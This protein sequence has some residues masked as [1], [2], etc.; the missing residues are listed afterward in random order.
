M[1]EGQDATLLQRRA[2]RRLVGSVAL[3]LLVVLVLPI[4]LD[5]EPSPVSQDLVIQIPSKDAGKFN[6]RVLPPSAP[7]A[8]DAGKVEAEK[9]AKTDA[10]KPASDT[11]PAPATKVQASK[12]ERTAKA[13]PDAARALALLE[14]KEAGGWVIPLGAFSNSENVKQLRAR[15]TSA[16]IKSY[17]ETVKG[18]Q[19]EQ[20]RVRAGPFDNKVTA[21]NTREKL[22]AMGLRPSAVTTR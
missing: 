3:L 21:E 9:L 6:T 22:G 2:R 12:A 10:A 13:E 4:V 14:G 1:A 16:G 17:T 20:V 5:R 11:K 7:G 15:L 18:P 8:P 19:G